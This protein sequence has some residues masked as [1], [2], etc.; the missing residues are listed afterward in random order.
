MRQE[1]AASSAIFT[2]NQFG[3]RYLSDLTPAKMSARPYADI[4]QSRYAPLELSAEQTYI[5]LGTDSGLLI[6]AFAASYADSPLALVFI[7]HEDYIDAIAA[8]CRTELESMEFVKLL[9]V[10]QLRAELEATTF[11]SALLT[12]RAAAINSL[13]AELD[14]AV[15][16]RS[17]IEQSAFLIDSRRW[18][19]V[20]ITLRLPSLQQ[21]LLNIPEMRV[22][23]SALSGKLQGHTVVVMAAGPSLDDHLDWVQ[24]NRDKLV[25]V[26]V[27]RI[28]RRLLEKGIV[29]DIIATLDPHE[30]S[31]EVSREALKFEPSP[32]LAFSDQAVN[33]LVGQWP[34]PKVYLG[35][36]LPWKGE[37]F[38]LSTQA[39]TVSNLAFDIAACLTPKQI[40]LMGLDFCLDEAG[41]THAMGNME[42]DTG[43]SLRTDMEE[44]T[45]YDG[46]IRLSSVDYLNSGLEL[47]K[48]IARTANIA[49]IN[50][51]PG[52]MK[53]DGVQFT[54]LAR[55][56]TASDDTTQP[57]AALRTDITQSASAGQWLSQA[58]SA[59]AK[60]LRELD[61]LSKLASDGIKSVKAIT[62]SSGDMH[63]HLA[64]LDAIDKRIRNRY[65]P[66]RRFCL[67]NCSNF[68]TDIIDT[69]ATVNDDQTES[70]V[71]KSRMVY[72]AYKKC[73]TVVRPMLIEC[74]DR[75]KLRQHETDEQ[76]P[77]ALAE[78]FLSLGLPGRILNSSATLPAS[79]IDAAKQLQQ[80][81]DTLKTERL[82]GV[83]QSMEVSADSLFRT[84]TA[85]YQQK[86]IDKLTHYKNAISRMQD[87]DQSHL[88]LSL[89]NAYLH[90]V[91]NDEQ[92]ALSHY[93]DIV[94]MGENPLLEEAL[95][96]IAF[97]SI[98]I[99][100][101]Q[102]AA[103]ALTVLCKVNPSYKT[104]LDQLEA[105]A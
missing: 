21:R 19:V 16:Y 29:P 26:S 43:V 58:H 24:A 70:S 98:R 7:E 76:W 5:V 41:H 54:P 17:I 69:G 50:P 88:F 34:G 102:T 40:I 45:T 28:S 103:Q 35:S 47:Q 56:T 92:A 31:F 86:S 65:L 93:M 8:E 39:Q 63:K 48:Q 72:R 66:H 67:N 25:I 62:S 52:A 11:D 44:V 91:T 101:Q 27:S 60:F 13:S 84:L 42:R 71:D 83:L 53:L 90:E 2:T 37:D 33:K 46:S 1:D 61:E 6:K 32:I 3:D 10:E 68:F 100:D 75:L 9:T 36:R 51:S 85:A 104:A 97:L 87:F 38:E 59:T 55:V 20:G 18:L 64:R 49:V 22:A 81:Q 30:I 94:E 89:A 4:W 78:E 95:N 80:T 57:L 99:G 74:R 79:V 23:A 12:G 82:Q 73:V 77:E 105:A 14:Q 96:R 15:I